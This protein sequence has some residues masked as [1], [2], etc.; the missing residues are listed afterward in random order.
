MQPVNL[1]DMTPETL[2]VYEFI[3]G[4]FK[5][6]ERAWGL[7]LTNFIAVPQLFLMLTALLLIFASLVNVHGP[8]LRVK[9][10]KGSIMGGGFLLAVGTGAA[11]VAICLNW[12]A[13]PSLSA[14]AALLPLIGLTFMGI[15]LIATT[16][17]VYDAA[18]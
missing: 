6:A 9:V 10:L 11:C 2:N 1:S 14:I 15:G 13:A 16:H 18:C 7:A 12:S 8:A 3:P 4:M 17:T 5:L